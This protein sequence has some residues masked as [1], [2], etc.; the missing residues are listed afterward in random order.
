YAQD[1]IFVTGRK[2]L[3][4]PEG[5]DG[6]ASSD[7]EL[8]AAGGGPALDCAGICVRKACQ[9][10]PGR[11]QRGHDILHVPAL[12]RR[13]IYIARADAKRD[14]VVDDA[15]RSGPTGLVKDIGRLDPGGI[16]FAMGGSERQSLERPKRD[17][18]VDHEDTASTHKVDLR[19]RVDVA[20]GDA[21]DVG[22]GAVSLRDHM[23][24]PVVGRIPVFV[25]FGDMGFEKFADHRGDRAGP[26]PIIAREYEAIERVTQDLCQRV[27]DPDKQVR[28]ACAAQHAQ[29]S[30]G[31]E[32]VDGM[33]G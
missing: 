19:P 1:Q 33:G 11:R 30:V 28:A 6:I 16:Q 14:R 32:I 3:R 27:I 23:R 17:G 25:A 26:G 13:S 9:T 18:H 4:Y 2:R 15:C 7:D 5:L 22:A 20:A 29:P 31:K 24:W 10:G 12:F 8:V 21:V